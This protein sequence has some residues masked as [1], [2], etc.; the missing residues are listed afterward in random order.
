VDCERF[1][2]KSSKSGE[3][4]M[5]NRYWASGVV[6]T[7]A[8][9]VGCKQEGNIT[10]AAVGKPSAEGEKYVLPTEPDAAQS[11]QSARTA[12]ETEDEVVVA[13][14]IGGSVDPWLE[15][16]AAFSIVDPSLK[17]CNAIPGDNCPTPWDYCCESNLKDSMA[18][19]KIVDDGGNVVQSDAR[20]LLGVK[21]LDTVVV[22]GKAQR[23]DAGNLTI[24][25]SGVHV[26]H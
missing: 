15:G 11:V 21:E 22:R 1:D 26:R 13:G 7:V 16:I 20:T 23:D 9:V 17:A 10:P 4:Q 3:I 5:R 18:L 25:A 2:F 14:R 24:L 12:A 6:I 19:V 8:L